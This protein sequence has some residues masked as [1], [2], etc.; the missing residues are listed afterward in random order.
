MAEEHN[1]Y[2]WKGPH[3]ES[4]WQP[5]PI[6]RNGAANQEK[7]AE[8]SDVNNPS[9]N[10]EYGA[11]Q[12]PQNDNTPQDS[13]ETQNYTDF[14]VPSIPSMSD[15]LNTQR[16]TPLPTVHAGDSSSGDDAQQTRVVPTADSEDTF[17]LRGLGAG[18]QRYDGFVAPRSD[19]SAGQGQG[20]E[21]NQTSDGGEVH[22][23]P[24]YESGQTQQIQPMQPAQPTEQFAQ[25]SSVQYG[26]PGYHAAGVS[27]ATEQEPQGMPEAQGAQQTQYRP[28]PQYGAYA[29]RQDNV[30]PQ[31]TQGQNAQYGA[32]QEQNNPFIPEYGASDGGQIPPQTPGRTRAEPRREQRWQGRQQDAEHGD[33]GGYRR[34]A[35]RRTDARSGWAAISNG[36]ISGPTTSSLSGINSNSSGSGSATA[37]SGEA[38]DWEAVSKS[39]SNSVVAIDTVV[40]GVER[41]KAPAQSSTRQVRW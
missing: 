37:K 40:L 38:A 9:V 32:P 11:A 36:L 30:Q 25:P 26:Q 23:Q 18:T 20:Q 5:S 7:N 13:Q 19:E 39:V 1:L 3:D 34:C 27:G 22:P 16:T 12:D 33:G 15:S 31:E 4:S 17:A 21:R 2:P 24:S 35:Q 10:G 6:A 29:P 28:A 41:P 8:Q 14:G